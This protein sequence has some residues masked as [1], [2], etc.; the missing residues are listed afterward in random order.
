MQF[1]AHRAEGWSALPASFFASLMRFSAGPLVV[2][3]RQHS[4]SAGHVGGQ[5]AVELRGI[6][7]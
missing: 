2:E 6:G 4:D 7:I 3:P 1:I 5:Y